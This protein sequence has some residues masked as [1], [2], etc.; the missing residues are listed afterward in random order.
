MAGKMQAY[1]AVCGILLNA[2]QI[3]LIEVHSNKGKNCDYKYT[4]K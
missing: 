2:M 3:I 4:G 1:K